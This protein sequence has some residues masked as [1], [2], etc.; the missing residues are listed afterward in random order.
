MAIVENQIGTLEK[1]VSDL[2]EILQHT[3]IHLDKIT[4]YSINNMPYVTLHKLEHLSNE[5]KYA[6]EHS[7]NKPKLLASDF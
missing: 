3:K 2:T 4:I 1:Q 7:K 6:I 5:I